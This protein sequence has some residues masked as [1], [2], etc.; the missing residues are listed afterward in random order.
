MKSKLITG[1]ST[2]VA[3]VGLN[4]GAAF[5]DTAKVTLCHA[6]AS[7]TNPYV[8][9]T[10]AT[11]GAYHGHYTQHQGA[12][13]PGSGGKWGDI[14]PPFS[15]QNQNYQLNWDAAG[16]AIFNNGCQV[17]GGSGGGGGGNSGGGGGTTGGG[18]G[19]QTTTPPVVTTNN[20]ITTNSSGGTGGESGGGEASSQAATP[21]GG[22]N[23][24]GGGEASTES[25]GALA[26]LVGSLAAAGFGLRRYGKHSF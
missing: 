1:L 21:S 18:G 2:I 3:I 7:N 17:P 24:G 10:V 15:Y 23:A 14:I 26:G 20:T 4:L 25:L 12:V 5:A 9:I 22:V 16:Q 6:T 8:R 13:Y 19:G 11:A